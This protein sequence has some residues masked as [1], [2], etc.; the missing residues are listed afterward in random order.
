[1]PEGDLDEYEE[2]VPPELLGEAP[3]D[4]LGIA[5]ADLGI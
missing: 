2:V 3:P 1:V 4:H 5:D